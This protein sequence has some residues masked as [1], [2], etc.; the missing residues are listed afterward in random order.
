MLAIAAAVVFAIAF[1]L[2]IAQTG[3]GPL[4]NAGTLTVLGLLLL[5]LHLAPLGTFRGRRFRR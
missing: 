2:D 1:I 3:S 5:A 4:F